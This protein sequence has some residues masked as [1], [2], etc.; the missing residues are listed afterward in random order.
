LKLPVCESVDPAVSDPTEAFRLALFAARDFLIPIT[1]PRIE[2][3]KAV[4]ACFIVP[5]PRPKVRKP[6]KRTRRKP[7]SHA[8]TGDQAAGQPDPGKLG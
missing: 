1:L 8:A 3:E 4:R 2:V 6:R 5:E 7:V